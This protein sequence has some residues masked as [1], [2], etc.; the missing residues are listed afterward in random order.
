MNLKFG[1]IKHNFQFK[2]MFK[3]NILNQ[4]EYENHQVDGM[5]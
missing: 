2:Q 5:L 3:V 1:N 4:H